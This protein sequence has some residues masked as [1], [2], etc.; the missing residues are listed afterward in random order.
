MGLG[1]TAVRSQLDP[2]QLKSFLIRDS[3]L[4]TATILPMP[5]RPSEK[6]FVTI[7]TARCFTG[8]WH[9]RLV[10][11]PTAAF[12]TFPTI[13]NMR[14]ERPSTLLAHARRKLRPWNRR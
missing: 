3:G 7:P 13:Q 9:S 10:Q 12:W 11:F 14:D 5:Q 6:L 4:S 1:V 2:N 8:A